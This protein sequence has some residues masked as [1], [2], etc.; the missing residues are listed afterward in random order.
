MSFRFKTI[1]GIASIE[2]ILLMILI[3][4]VLGFL[5]S[6][7]EKEINQRALSTSK[8]FATMSKDAV[9]SSDLASLETF[10]DEILS[11]ED[12]VYAKI[13]GDG[14]LLAQGGKQQYLKRRFIKDTA[15]EKVNDGVFD[16]T[17]VIK[18]SNYTYGR[19]ELGLSI[20]RIDQVLNQAS[21][22]SVGIA[23]VEIMLVGIFSFILG[24]W[25]TRQL[26]QLKKASDTITQS[27]PGHQVKVTGND[28]ISQVASSFNQMS[29]SLSES[30]LSLKDSNLAYQKVAELAKKNEN[31]LLLSA[32]AFEAH[33]A[34]FISNSDNKIVRINKAFTKITG[35]RAD[36]VIGKN[37]SIL[38]SKKQDRH[39]YKKMWQ[40][41][42]ET[43]HWEGEIY[44]RRKNGDIYPEWLGVSSVKDS[45]GHKLYYVA[46]FVDL[47]KRLEAEEKLTLA[48]KE[49]EQANEAKSDF[50]A[51]MSHEIRTPMNAILG[52]LE[53]MQSTHLDQEQGLYVD[54]AN[55]SAKSLLNLING[56]LDFSK[57][58]ADKLEIIKSPFNLKL[59]IDEC[60]NMLSEKARLHNN[61]VKIII[62]PQ[63][64]EFLS[65]DKDRIK[66]VLI[67]LLNNALK[68][69]HNGMVTCVVNVLK[70]ET[71]KLQ[72]KF[73][74]MDTGIGISEPEQQNLFEVFSQVD[75]KHNRRFDGTGLGLAISKRLVNLMGG[76]IGVNSVPDKGS[77]FWFTLTLDTVAPEFVME[78]DLEPQLAT[79]QQQKQKYFDPSC[80]RILLVEDSLANLIVAKSVLSKAG[81]TV[82]VAENGRLAIDSIEQSIQQQADFDI[83]L[84]DL[85]MPEMD[86]V[87][88]TKIIR[89]M[90]GEIAQIPILAMTANAY[91]GDKEY[92]IKSGMDDYISKPYASIDLL[93]KIAKLLMAHQKQANSVLKRPN[94]LN[95]AVTDS[96]TADT[97]IKSKP[98]SLREP[99]SINTPIVDEVPL[100][101]LSI[102]KQLEKDTSVELV[103]E[104]VT[105]FI[106]ELNKRLV[107]VQQA[108]Q[109]QEIKNIASEVHAL[110]SSS[111]TYGA[112]KLELISK[113][114]DLAC[115]NNLHA[116][117]MSMSPILV[118][119]ITQTIEAYTKHFRLKD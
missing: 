35:Y 64:P 105:I 90:S 82:E 102:I 2:S 111:A 21:Q 48:R 68:F 52:T 37:P 45:D 23:I 58:E 119:E 72:L 34:I 17:A 96:I 116:E 78:P 70:Q 54:T 15:L 30:Y 19:V 25:L 47:T 4:S 1:V 118:A 80:Y 11:N 88:A 26:S 83:I 95:S 106:K 6:S 18:E 24:T 92:C 79:I 89:Q 56:I 114:T 103:P 117:V 74:L 85:M 10:I 66:Q 49:A 22:W 86:G 9:L 98:D 112:L 87:E 40:Q 75:Q 32:T 73:E 76:E 65:S 31:E 33:E 94:S 115:K 109:Q 101:D 5:K 38:S 97:S 43:G 51:T 27:G 113:K 39:F 57:I 100:I 104:M 20:A 12:I 29:K 36:E 8:L 81:Y 53:L 3:F 55:T 50:L 7:H 59:L 13:Y 61:T 69:T 14:N 67:N 107:N 44:N 28:E 93:A 110:K 84:M 77:N 46:H 91:M 63:I 71:K 16:V 99:Q 62:A 42:N 60:C 108:I 41:I